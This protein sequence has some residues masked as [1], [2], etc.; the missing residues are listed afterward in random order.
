ML[1][2][3]VLT[4][5]KKS[6]VSSLLLGVY[7]GDEL[8]YAGRAG[9]GISEAGMRALES[10]FASL[11][12][13]ASPF[14]TAPKPAP[15][16]KLTWLEP[17]LVAEIK[18]AEWTRDGHLR[19]ASFKGLRGDKNPKTI[20]RESAE[21]DWQPEF[22]EGA[23]MPM[24]T[25]TSGPTT[26]SGKA[27]T[28]A[29][30][31]SE[32]VKPSPETV[33]SQSAT[34]RPTSGTV[35]ALGKPAASIANPATTTK[36]SAKAA[37]VVIEGV[38]ISNPG[39]VLFQSPLVTKEEVIR[40]YAAISERM[41]PYVSRR[42]VTSVRCPKGVSEN[43]F[44]KK[45]P[46]PGS[47]GVIPF[48]VTN[49]SG[50]MEDYF[51]IED[52]AGLIHEAQMGTL[53]F[54][55]WGSTI[56]E[57]EKPDIMVFD[58][59]PDEGMELDRIRQ[60]A[61]DIKSI[62]SELSLKSYL[63]TSGGKGYHVVVP[64]RPVM[65]WEAFN[66]FAKTVAQVMEQKWPDRYT[67]NVR[68]AKRVDKIFI[69]WIRNGRGATS[70]APYSVRAREGASVSMPIAWEELDTIPPDGINMADALRRLG[71]NDPWR[72]FFKG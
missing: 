55:T 31:L 26:T 50:K 57:L 6:G 9:T 1:G 72:D 35:K 47:K 71:G 40:Y 61:K 24:T 14:G 23:E 28:T 43:C 69:D 27:S 29:K 30:L 20:K 42:I 65:E 33:H 54:H 49:S 53:E 2:G 66:D 51:Y 39:K 70:I 46:G 8:I 4:D 38:K 15:K 37:S 44:Y 13:E 58:L 21:G 7:E 45:H 19:Q 67:S 25:T 59:D 60:G 5:K 52:T 11:S 10:K 22:D 68:K 63:K 41:L 36:T 34:T 56:D 12:R 16:E 32:T 64:F 3:Y 48:P 18:F 62:L 17:N